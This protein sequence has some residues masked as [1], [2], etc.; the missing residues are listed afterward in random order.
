ME[1]HNIG[2]DT[3]LLFAYGHHN[4]DS[5]KKIVNDEYSS[6]GDFFESA[7]LTYYVKRGN[8]Y[9]TW[10]HPTNKF[11]KNAFPVTV[12][13][14]GW[15]VNCN[16]SYLNRSTL[17]K[18]FSNYHIIKGVFKP[19]EIIYDNHIELY[20]YVERFNTILECDNLIIELINSGKI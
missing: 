8:Q 7:Y 19:Y 16:K 10:F 18:S 15:S 5:F 6:W 2:S 13:Q 4:L 11:T 20:H 3:Y 12:A 1:L 17:I 14:E 9:G